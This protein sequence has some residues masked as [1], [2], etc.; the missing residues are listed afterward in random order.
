[1]V[2]DPAA[3]AV[4]GDPA[5]DDDRELEALVGAAL[6]LGDAG[7]AGALEDLPLGVGAGRARAVALDQADDGELA[8]LGLDDDVVPGPQPAGAGAEDRR[9]RGLREDAG[10]GHR[11]AF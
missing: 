2:F 9:D 5:L 11:R 6:P 8:L 3:A 1:V 7:V 4:A 10:A